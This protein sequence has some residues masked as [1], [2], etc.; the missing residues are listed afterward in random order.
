VAILVNV[1]TPKNLTAI[2][3]N[4][5]DILIAVLS[6]IIVVILTANRETGA[7]QLIQIN[8]GSFVMYLVA[9]NCQSVSLLFVWKRCTEKYKLLFDINL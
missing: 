2:V 6:E 1:G 3:G 7:T 9:I 5:G 4:L 8:D